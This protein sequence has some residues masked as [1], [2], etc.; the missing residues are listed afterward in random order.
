M[1]CGQCAINAARRRGDNYQFV[2]TDG[3]NTVVYEDEMAA[4]AKVLRKGGSYQRKEK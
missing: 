3:D 4:K 2:W 1:A